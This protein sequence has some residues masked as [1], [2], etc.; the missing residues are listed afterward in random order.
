MKSKGEKNSPMEKKNKNKIIEEVLDEFG[1]YYFPL[2]SGKNNQSEVKLNCDILIRIIERTMDK[3][4][5]A[6][7]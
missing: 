7:K 6:K 5:G 2:D 3:L 1:I 4:K